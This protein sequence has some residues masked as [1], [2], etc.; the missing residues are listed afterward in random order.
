MKLRLAMMLAGLGLAFTA[1]TGSARA[2]IASTCGNIDVEANAKCEVQ[3]D[4]MC[5]ANCT[6]P[7]VEVSCA[8][9]LEASCTQKGKCEIAASADCTTA[10]DLKGCEADC[11]VDPGS[12]DCT[13]QCKAEASAKC[14]G[15]CMGMAADGQ[16]HGEC[17]ASCQASASAECSGSCK[18]T[19]P[20]AN[21]Q[22]KCQAKC[23]ASCTAQARAHC[24]VDCQASGYATCEGTLTAQC[25]GECSKPEGALFC[26]GQYID[27][28]GN[29]QSCIDQID[30]WLKAHVDVSAQ[31]TAM[32][33]CNNGSCQ[34]E[35][36]GSAKASCAMSPG[37]PASGWGAALLAL[38]GAAVI[39]RRRRR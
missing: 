10:C 24:Q 16:A 12:F 29:L 6:E 11:N 22:A 32:G 31:G 25:N 15:E 4:V 35:A 5:K 9:Q 7:K 20:S 27:H 3:A 17:M 1:W 2:D 14:D 23:D 39:A 30:A 28:D 18:G 36:E 34:G 33:Q 37:A 13:A 38:T 21:C 26:D 8:A 19:P